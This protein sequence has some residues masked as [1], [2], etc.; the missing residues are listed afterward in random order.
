[1]KSVALAMI[2]WY[3]RNLSGSLPGGCRYQPTCADYSYEA[4]E[5]FGVVKGVG[6]GVWRLAR[7]HPF[8]KGGLDPVPERKSAGDPAGKLRGTR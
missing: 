4:I 6:L 7:C 3:K 2:R 8:A 5:R 1:M